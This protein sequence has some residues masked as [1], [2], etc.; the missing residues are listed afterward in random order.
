MLNQFELSQTQSREYTEE[1]EALFLSVKAAR[2]YYSKQ[3][4]YNELS[5]E[6][7]GRYQKWLLNSEA[8]QERATTTAEPMSINTK[9]YTF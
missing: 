2:D 1:E 3:K 5:D 6:Q 4:K 8:A 9:L 7:K